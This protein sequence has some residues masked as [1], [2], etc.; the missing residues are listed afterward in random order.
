MQRAAD[1]HG[2]FVLQMLSRLNNTCLPLQ[3]RAMSFGKRPFG[4]CLVSPEGEVLLT[5]QSVDVVNHSESSLARIAV[6][7]FSL[8]YLWTCTLYSTWEPCAM[9][10]ATIYWANIGRVV[11]GASNDTLKALT[12]ELLPSELES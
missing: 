3:R 2:A 10:P 12:G 11:F 7:H 6:Q 9:R 8:P 1:L 5:H 4:S